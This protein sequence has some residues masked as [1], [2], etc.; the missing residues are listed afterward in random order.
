MDTINIFDRNFIQYDPCSTHG[1]TPKSI[2]YTTF[3][4]DWDGVTLYTDHC[5]HHAQ[6]TKSK[7]KI[8]WQVESPI[9]SDKQFYPAMKKYWDYFDYVF[10]YD[11]NLVDK[12]PEK[13]KP[14]NFAGTTVESHEWNPNPR[15]NFCI[16]HSGKRDSQNHA[17]RKYIIDNLSKKYDI[18]VFGRVTGNPFNNI[19]TIYRNYKYPIVIENVDHI[20]YFSEKLTDALACACIPIYK[21][22]FPSTYGK[23]FDSDGII[24]F[25]TLEELEWILKSFSEG[26][27]TFDSKDA[28]YENYKITHRDF[29]TNEDWLYKTYIKDI[30][31]G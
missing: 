16:I 26:V 18:D 6:Q 3:Q 1:K 17:L 23:F 27:D 8:A 24:Y 30:L 25:S 19:E 5:F 10:T 21:G 31:H 28:R 13:C 14:V 20:N 12:F 2:S 9:H 22:T 29:Y 15:K 4:K 11:Q 7:F